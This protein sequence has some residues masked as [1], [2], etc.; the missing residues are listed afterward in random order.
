MTLT[1]LLRL[2]VASLCLYVSLFSWAQVPKSGV[3][4]GVDGP[5][6]I[7]DI[8]WTGP[9]GSGQMCWYTRD[10]RGFVIDK[11]HCGVPEVRGCGLAV[12]QETCRPK[13]NKICAPTLMTTPSWM[14]LQ[15]VCQSFNPSIT[16]Q[17]DM[18]KAIGNLPNP[19]D[20]IVDPSGSLSCIVGKTCDVNI[21]DG[22]LIDIILRLDSNLAKGSP[23]TIKGQACQHLVSCQRM[24]TGDVYPLGVFS[25]GGVIP[26]LPSWMKLP[27]L[28]IDV[29]VG[30]NGS[31]WVIGISEIGVG[32]NGIYRLDNGN[33]NQ[34]PGAA[35]RI[36]VDGKGNAWVVTKNEEIYRWNGSGWDRLP[37][38]AKDIGVNASGQAWIVTTTPAPGG[39]LPARW[40]GNGWDLTAFNTG[41][42]RIAVDSKGLAW[43]VNASNKIMQ[44]ES[45]SANPNSLSLITRYGLGTDIGIG[46][47]DTVFLVGMDGAPWKYNRSNG[48]W[49]RYE[50]G[51][52]GV[53]SIA[54]SGTG[55]PY[56]VT[57][58]G[59]IY[60]GTVR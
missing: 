23:L 54:V 10:A 9:S 16:Y 34:I 27:G 30:S 44:F 8:Y 50:V 37:G 3:Y 32:G 18:S 40:N 59:D 4:N 6:S 29:G 25:T 57:K 15:E 2:L 22:R 51:A 39:Y 36:S 11:S 20:T 35:T 45:S 33:W 38:T 12:D 47:D 52:S 31:V 58:S 19:G 42:T 48:Q 17:V 21:F 41:F 46:A 24:L 26:P 56:G 14:P 49:S 53:S 7:T 43:G 13:D 1:K 28:A 5:A 60:R 55:F